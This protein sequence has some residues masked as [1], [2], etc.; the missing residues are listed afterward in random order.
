MSSFQID[1]T[2]SLDPTVGVLLNLSPDHL[3]RHGPAD[4]A[5]LAMRNYSGIKERLVRASEAVC[6]GFEDVHTCA[7]LE[8]LEDAGARL[9][10]FTTGK[11]AAAVPRLYAIGTTLFVHEQHPGHAASTEIASLDG[12]GT[13]RGRHNVQNALAALAALR[14]LQD[15]LDATH[16]SS[17]PR[18]LIWHL[19]QLGPALATYPGLPH[20]M[21]QVGRSGAVLF[22]N[23]SKAT[24]ADSTEKALASWARD[25]FWIL[26][27]KPKEGGIRP[28][29]ALFSRVTKAYLMGEASDDFA[30]TLQGKVAFE[31]C[32]TLDVALAK[33][34]ADAALST[35]S[36]P[37]V[38]LSPACASYDQFRSFEHRGDVFR[39]MVRALPGV[40]G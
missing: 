4:D 15:R 13:L 11:A 2:P 14:A 35:G 30:S 1:L 19:P 36:E 5:D 31:R 34:A 28:L 7:I 12:I 20:R 16:A 17:A 37:V 27:G 32:V 8:R 26:G 40:T 9:Y 23:D 10:P 6:I 22:I 3:D 38:L 33:A 29:E 21:E 39:E 24:N 18:S 25:I